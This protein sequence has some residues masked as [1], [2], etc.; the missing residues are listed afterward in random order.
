[1][2]TYESVNL[3]HDLDERIKIMQQYCKKKVLVLDPTLDE[4]RYTSGIL[5]KVIKSKKKYFLK[6]S[7]NGITK[8]RELKVGN[9]ERFFVQTQTSQTHNSS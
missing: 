4:I 2:A 1:M 3:P 5:D 7:N 9:I 8:K 6:I